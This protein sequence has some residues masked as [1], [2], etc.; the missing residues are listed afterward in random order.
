[1]QRFV[2]DQAE[3]VIER[4]RNDPLVNGLEVSLG[5]CGIVGECNFKSVLHDQRQHVSA[6]LAAQYRPCIACRQQ[7]GNTSDMVIVD[8]SD[9]QR[10]D[11]LGVEIERC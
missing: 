10:P 5:L 11:A 8:V 4:Q 1:M 3:P 7:F 2:I 6:G 9:Q